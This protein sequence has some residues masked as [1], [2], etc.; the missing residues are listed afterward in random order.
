MTASYS[1]S[2]F[3]IRLF[4]V[5]CFGFHP[6]VSDA[7]EQEVIKTDVAGDLPREHEQYCETEEDTVDTG[8]TSHDEVPVHE[9]AK[10]GG[11]TDE[12]ASDEENAEEQ[13]TDGDDFRKQV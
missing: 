13:F 2:F 6:Q 4:L 5:I 8:G 7:G 3:Y 9:A 11:G 12:D 1:P 10:E